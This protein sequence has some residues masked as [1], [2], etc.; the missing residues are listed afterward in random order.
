MEWILC[1]KETQNGFGD[2]KETGVGRQARVGAFRG[3]GALS[4]VAMR[5]IP[6]RRA[7]AEEET[8]RELRAEGGERVGEG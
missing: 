7:E 5:R 1:L 3:G 4:R 6:R 8:P 2:F